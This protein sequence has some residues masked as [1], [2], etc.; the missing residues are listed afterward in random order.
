M[1]I[2]GAACIL[3]TVL[4]T[5]GMMEIGFTA[6]HI[7]ELQ[8]ASDATALANA[9]LPLVMPSPDYLSAGSIPTQQY[10]PGNARTS[11]SGTNRLSRMVLRSQSVAMAQ[12]SLLNS[13]P[14]IASASGPHLT[15]S[16]FF[17]ATANEVRSSNAAISQFQWTQVQPIPIRVVLLLDMSSSMTLPTVPNGPSALSELILRAQDLLNPA[18]VGQGYV[19]WGYYPYANDTV[20]S[21]QYA[22]RPLSCKSG[23][24]RTD[25]ELRAQADTVLNA[26]NA[27]T[28]VLG[29]CTNLE[30]AIIEVASWDEAKR[31]PNAPNCGSVKFIIISD[32]E[33]TT[34]NAVS[35][36]CGTSTANADVAPAIAAATKAIA[37][38][39]SPAVDGPRDILSVILD[40]TFGNGGFNESQALTFMKDIACAG[41]LG[42]RG[43]PCNHSNDAN[44]FLQLQNTATV[45]DVSADTLRRQMHCHGVQF[46]PP[47]DNYCQAPDPNGIIMNGF[48]L[49][50]RVGGSDETFVYRRASRYTIDSLPPVG[51]IRPAE[52]FFY[53]VANESVLLNAA[54]CSDYVDT[55]R[56]HRPFRFRLRWGIPMLNANPDPGHKAN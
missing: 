28:G 50:S 21:N 33:P 56:T 10:V 32:G 8:D 52:A 29:N 34:Y 11:D 39:V 54:I 5:M 24:I 20:K 2:L 9:Y 55:L 31:H 14:S 53:D 3:F 4:L 17:P 18:D 16:Q 51:T 41:E 22:V 49:P 46:R 45:L 36:Q 43:P 7:L 35:S 44:Y 27:H 37:D 47:Q 42:D 30:D 13:T 48:W 6:L 26:V 1:A 40:R 12:P 25:V 23:P 15:L 19:N 38:A